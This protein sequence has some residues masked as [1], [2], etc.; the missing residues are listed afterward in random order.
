MTSRFPA[1]KRFCPWATLLM[2]VLSEPHHPQEN[3]PLK[4]GSATPR[5][6]T[7]TGPWPVRNRASQEEVSSKRAKPHLGL[8]IAGVTA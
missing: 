7:G 3:L 6:Q 8:P 2:A 1:A 4:Q 5:S